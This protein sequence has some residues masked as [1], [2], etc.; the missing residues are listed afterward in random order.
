MAF[1]TGT[2]TG[3]AD[4]ISKLA[5]FAAANGWTIGAATSGSV[6]INSSRGLYFGVSTG[7]S[8]V[9]LKGATGH[10]ASL[11]WD[12]QPGYPTE[13]NSLTTVNDCAGPLK[14]YYF[15]GTEQYLHVVVETVT[16]KFKHFA[17]GQLE[18]NSTYTGGA[19][20]DGSS[21]N[22]TGDAGTNFPDAPS[23]RYL[24]DAVG[25]GATGGSGRI[26]VDIDGKTN[27]WMNYGS[28]GAF[29]TESNM[30]KGVTRSQNSFLAAFHAAGP[31][32]FNQ[33][34]V[35]TPILVAAARG[36]SLFSLIGAPKDLRLVNMRNLNPGQ[37]MTIG[38]DEWYV[39][40]HI[41]K[42]L[43]FNSNGSF[44]PSSGTYGYAY[45]KVV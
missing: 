14:L 17:I 9:S 35:L 5:T 36:S 8:T 37:I 18:K 23:H 11:A 26:R 13:A 41:Q 4:L 20:V 42:S 32:D 27:N 39:F 7:A 12:L 29:A 43:V 31:N 15:F 16:N 28:S 25:T 40:P 38:S 10:N 33:R 19:Y 3:P 44:V 1:Q 6:F 24:F 21:H 30:I 22:M 34:T 45:K 2:S